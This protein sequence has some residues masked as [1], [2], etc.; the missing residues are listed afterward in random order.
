MPRTRRAPYGRVRTLRKYIVSGEHRF[1]Y[2]VVQKVAC[3]SIKVTLLPLLDIDTA[4]EDVTGYEVVSKPGAPDRK[5]RRIHKLFDRSEHQINKRALLEGLDDEYRDYFKFA[6]VRNPWYRL[7]SCYSDKLREGGK[8]MWLP[9]DA[10]ASVYPGMPFDE[11]V[12]AV[13]AIP[14]GKANIHFRSQYQ[15]L[16]NRRGRIMADFVGRFENIQEDFARVAERIGLPGL[17]LSHRLH[18]GNRRDR[19]YTE[20]YDDR[21]RDLVHERFQTDVEMFGYSFDGSSPPR[22]FDY[23]AAPPPGTP[24][25]RPESVT[26]SQYGRRR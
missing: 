20:F 12:E 19:S 6:F 21:L 16:C 8:G 24:S 22:G 7:V 14:D 15:T 1:I 26:W 5:V 13:H 18:S 23:P 3:T 10:G 2:F 9:D 11:F 17:E 25:Q 4:G